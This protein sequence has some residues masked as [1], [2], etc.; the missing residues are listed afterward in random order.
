[1]AAEAT[2]K[3]MGNMHQLMDE[4]FGPIRFIEL[5]E[6]FGYDLNDVVGLKIEGALHDPGQPVTPRQS[7]P[8]G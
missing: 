1:M 6:L 5:V 3:G 4:H 8:A 7:P 2:A